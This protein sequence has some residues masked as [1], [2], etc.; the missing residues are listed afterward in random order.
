VKLFIFSKIGLPENLSKFIS[1]TKSYGLRL[2]FKKS[3]EKLRKIGSM[4]S[5]HF[6]KAFSRFIDITPSHDVDTLSYVCNICGKN[7]V[8]KISELRRE[9]VSCIHCGS[10]VR[11]RA[12]IHVLSMELFGESLAIQDF[13]ARPDIV[14]IGMSDWDGYAI[15][16]ARKFRYKNTYY[17]KDPKLD[18]TSIDPALEGMYDFIIS[19]DVFEHVLPPV[20]I[21]F[22][23]A[24]KLL[25]PGGVLIF[26]VPY[27][28][29]GTTIEHFPD[30]HKYEIIKKGDGYILKNITRDGVEQIFDNLFFHGGFGSTLEMRVFSESSLINEFQKAGFDKIK[31]Y[32]E[33]KYEFGIVWENNW[34]LPIAA[35]AKEIT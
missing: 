31:T 17:H 24:R 15:P 33:P 32:R 20:S 19:S 5:L 26:S 25:K 21:A 16:L 35:R 2:S 1:Y 4:R 12:I 18:I 3:H 9:E 34:S 30:L 27:T 7:C 11:M 13:P 23:N 6:K 10:T 14:G 29:D 22:E 8:T 28:K